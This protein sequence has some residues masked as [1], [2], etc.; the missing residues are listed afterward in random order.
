MKTEK[1]GNAIKKVKNPGS[2]K[3]F[4]NIEL[5]NKVGKQTTEEKSID[6]AKV[7]IS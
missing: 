5:R 1:T 7:N 4:L 6:C 2:A 3:R